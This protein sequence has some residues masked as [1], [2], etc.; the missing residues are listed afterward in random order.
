VRVAVNGPS[1]IWNV[2]ESGF[3][4][5][6]TNSELV[7][8]AYCPWISWVSLPASLANCKEEGSLKNCP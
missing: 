2:N 1:G 3:C 5:K 4:R 6:S 7:V 8:T